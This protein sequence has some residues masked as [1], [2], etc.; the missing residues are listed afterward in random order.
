MFAAAA[1]GDT[2]AIATIEQV[3]ILVVYVQCV[4]RYLGGRLFGSDVY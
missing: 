3:V 2:D 1:A 4:T